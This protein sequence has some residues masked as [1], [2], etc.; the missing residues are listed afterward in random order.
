MYCGVLSTGVPVVDAKVEVQEKV[1]AV[2]VVLWELVELVE[3]VEVEELDDEELDE[4]ECEDVEVEPD[5]VVDVEACV[6]VEVF[7]DGVKAPER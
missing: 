7:E 1:E 5:C 2:D 3:L 4:L 6:P